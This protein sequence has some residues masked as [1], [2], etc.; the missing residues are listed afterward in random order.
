MMGGMSTR[1]A[2]DA[3]ASSCSNAGKSKGTIRNRS[4]PSSNANAQSTYV[5]QMSFA[6]GS[7]KVAPQYRLDILAFVFD[8]QLCL[9]GFYRSSASLQ[10]IDLRLYAV[11]HRRSRREGSGQTASAPRETHGMWAHVVMCWRLA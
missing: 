3:K 10:Y 7:C 8:P 9:A 1:E 6:E 4:V 2:A 11:D 5:G